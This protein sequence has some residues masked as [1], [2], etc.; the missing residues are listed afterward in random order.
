MQRSSNSIANLAAAL[1]KA[2]I[3]LVNPEKELKT[4]EDVQTGVQHILAE[5]IAETAEVRA[6]TRSL[7]W[8]T[9]KICSAKSEKLADGQGLEYKDYFEF[10]EG[11]RQIPPHR[12]LAL[13]RGEK[14]TCLKVKLEWDNAA[15]QQLAL[16]ALAD[17]LSRPPAPP[18]P[19]PSQSPLP[20]QP[21]P[22]EGEAAIAVPEE[23]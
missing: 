9:G 7:L 23:A 8:E 12:I 21:L 11:L 16:A 3:A 20:E 15:V 22:A 4:V 14:E 17:H 5:M 6:V 19:P 1:S 18:P 10:N 2:Q 13:N